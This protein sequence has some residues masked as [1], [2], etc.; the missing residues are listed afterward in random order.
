MTLFTGKNKDGLIQ[1]YL[2]IILGV[3]T[4]VH[5]ITNR[6][7]WVKKPTKTVEQTRMALEAWLPKDLWQEVNHLL[8]GFGQQTCKPVGPLC[9]TC[10]NLSNCPFGQVS[11]KEKSKKKKT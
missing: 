1:K 7:G 9:H 10:I 8:V 5:R 3:D 11:V 2:F 4:H 6:I